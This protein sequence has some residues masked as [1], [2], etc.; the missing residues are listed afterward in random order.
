[1]SGNMGVRGQRRKAGSKQVVIARSAVAR[2]E[3]I[4]IRVRAVHRDCFAALAMTTR[5]ACPA[6]RRLAANRAALARLAR[7]VASAGFGVGSAS[8][9]AEKKAAGALAETARSP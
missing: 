1:M 4:S 9:A 8:T 5:A 6:L 2:D 3:A 7:V